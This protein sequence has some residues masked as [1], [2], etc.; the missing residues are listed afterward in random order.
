MPSPRVVPESEAGTSGKDTSWGRSV[1]D[2]V[3]D[4][5]QPQRSSPVNHGSSEPQAGSIIPLW[6]TLLCAVIGCLQVF[7][8]IAALAVILG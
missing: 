3:V 5:R 1:W 7:V 4:S 2:D 6:W 8:I